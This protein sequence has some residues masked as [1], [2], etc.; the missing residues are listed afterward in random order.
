MFSPNFFGFR[1]RQ[2]TPDHHLPRGHYANNDPVVP[3][4]KDKLKRWHEKMERIDTLRRD[5][6]SFP[7]SWR[8]KEALRRYTEEMRSITAHVKGE[9]SQKMGEKRLTWWKM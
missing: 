9:L 2:H 8:E 7:L 3:I 4:S 5:V 1:Q 6:E